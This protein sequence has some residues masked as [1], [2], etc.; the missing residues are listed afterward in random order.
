MKILGI[1]SSP[2]GKNSRTLKL[3]DAVLDGAKERG[4]ETELVDIAALDIRY[5]LG[6]QV[7]Y[8][9]GE[10]VQEDDLAELVDK[11]LSADGIVLGSPVYMHSVTAQLKTVIDRMADAIYC[12]LLSGK[13]GCSVT[14]SGG[15]GDAEVLDY[16]NHFLNELGVVTVGKV[17]VALDR[18]SAALDAAINKAF[19]L[20]TTLAESIQTKRAYPAQEKE[21]AERR[22]FFAQ[23][24]EEN[25]ADWPH[26][27]EYWMKKGWM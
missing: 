18:N 12:Q 4:A 11:M 6:C 1:N 16:M 5:C 9:E 22:A 17:G 20:G 14:T 25:K 7:C 21:I 3:V 24:I 26:Q 23:L 13:Y 27:Y 2:R 15:P 19:K 8:A 10:C